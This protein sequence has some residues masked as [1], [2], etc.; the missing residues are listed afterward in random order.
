MSLFVD[1]II[2]DIK[3]NPLSWTDWGGIGCANG[4]ILVCNYGNTRVLS[5]ISVLINSKEMPL[6][7]LDRWKLEVTVGEWYK[8]VPLK[9]L[10]KL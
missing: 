9:Q 8:S 4:N 7:Y 1:K 2:K 3:E 6:T 10:Q 5:V